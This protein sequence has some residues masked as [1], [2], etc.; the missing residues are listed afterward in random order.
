MDIIKEMHNIIRQVY[1]VLYSY[2]EYEYASRY[3]IG[4]SYYEKDIKNYDKSDLYSML[5]LFSIKGLIA[6]IVK[7]KEEL[8]KAIKNS[9]YIVYENNDT[10]TFIYTQDKIVV[11]TYRTNNI[12]EII[13]L[14]S[15]KIID[16]EIWD[17]MV[18]R[19][20][21]A[22]YVYY[23]EESLKFETDVY[24]KVYSTLPEY[25]KQ[26]RESQEIENNFNELL[27]SKEYNQW[28]EINIG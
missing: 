13:Y 5:A 9:E 21:D 22:H 14:L 24:N 8:H 28:L 20:A 2:S 6:N 3:R 16:K 18:D 12:K 4:I 10:F 26:Y 17:L 1:K 19:Y 7:T 27:E 11:K 15:S 25:L 23:D